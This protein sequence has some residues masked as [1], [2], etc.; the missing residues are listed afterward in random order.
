MYLLHNFLIDTYFEISFMDRVFFEENINQPII[1]VSRD[2][3]LEIPENFL[4][5][6]GHAL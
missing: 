3:N 1:S 5:E 4:K 6:Y 2:Q